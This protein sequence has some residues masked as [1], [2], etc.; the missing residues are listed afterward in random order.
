MTRGDGP[1]QA[2]VGKDGDGPV[3][4]IQRDGR[5]AYPDS[6]QQLLGVGMVGGA[7][8]LADDLQPLM[9]QAQAALSHAVGQSLLTLDDVV[10]RL[11]T[12]SNQELFLL[13][14]STQY[15]LAAVN[16]DSDDALAGGLC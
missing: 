7:G 14:N 12:A 15:A 3:D 2:A 13:E 5:H 8:Q 9:G 4:G 11:H 16:H 10:R 6:P 1:H